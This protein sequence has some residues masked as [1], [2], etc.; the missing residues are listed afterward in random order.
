LTRFV[1]YLKNRMITSVFTELV[2]DIEQ[3]N[4][5]AV[6]VSSLMDTWISLRNVELDGKRKKIVSIVKSRGMNHSLVIREM[7]LSEKGVSIR[8]S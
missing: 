8:E 6:G 5:R 4:F 2:T 1:D 3:L 7:R